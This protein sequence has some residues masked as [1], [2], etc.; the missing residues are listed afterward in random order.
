MSHIHR[1]LLLAIALSL[2][3]SACPSDSATSDTQDT[4][5]APDTADTADTAPVDTDTRDS[6]PAD[7]D[8]DQPPDVDTAPDA[9]P[10]T[11]PDVADT[12]TTDDA[13]LEDT[14]TSDTS[15]GDTAETDTVQGPVAVSRTHWRVTFEDDF[16]GPTGKPSDDYCYGELKPQCHIW[17]GGSFDCDLVGDDR[18]A[19]IEP[20]RDNFIAA[21][22]TL[23][24]DRDYAAMSLGEVKALYGQVIRDR[25]ANLD[26]CNWTL[27][28][29]VNWMATDY[30]G[31]WSARFDATQVE[32][33]TRGKGTL[34]LYAT[35]APMQTN[36]IFGGAGGDPNCQIH[37]FAAGALKVGVN[38]WVDPN[39]GWPGVYY[40]P[41]GGTCPNG[42]TFT[43]VNCLVYAFPPNV[44][45]AR[46][47]SY[48]AD[49]DP[50]WPGV[51]YANRAYACRDNIDYS[52]DL[53]FRNLTC[54]ILNGGVMSFPMTNR[55]WTDPDGVVQPRGVAQRRGRFEAKAK[56]PKGIGAF[57]AT[58][59]MPIEGGWPYKGGEIDVMEARD[60]ADEVYQTYH[61]GKCYDPTTKQRIDAEDSADC[62]R[63]GGA[64]THLSKGFTTR[65]R[66]S[67]EFWKRDHLYAVEWTETP[68]GDRLDYFIN[69]LKIGTI[70]VGTS[71]T[72]T[73]GAPP[74]LAAYERDN[75][76]TSPFYWILNH[77]TWVG[78]NNQASFAQ[79]TFAIDYVRNYV[80]CGTDP[81]EYC[82][83]GG[84]FVE[85]T[86]CIGPNGRVSPSPCQPSARPC[87]NGG[88]LVG[89]RCKVWDFAPGQIAAAP[90]YWVDPDPQWPGVYYAKVNGAC[91]YGGEGTV[92]CQIVG[93]PEGLVET[94]VSYLVDKTT[95]PPGVYYTPDFRD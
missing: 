70:Q 36:C 13:A 87:V 18:R 90:A 9:A 29:M 27:Y 61:N 63:K 67:D 74:Q 1:Q 79:Q 23:L 12:D 80:A 38:Y 85:G 37:A 6:G 73:E 35:R 14:D 83:Q 76:P 17:P 8:E 82:P 30:Q 72:L 86:G 91:P 47:V 4:V 81:R 55:L 59:L 53:A 69:N 71:G 22:K 28:T 24:P 56:I 11:A 39:P 48:W 58:W 62:A 20:V 45:E 2:P 95:S 89:G 46:D 44:L 84:R 77:S 75:F 5:F 10:D 57:P 21:L 43:G 16:R 49:A 15:S 41:T 68:A 32:V 88:E 92:N 50:R 78:A 66:V 19:P 40:A 34:R 42:G 25:L 64:T 60:A 33:D 54:P 52:P 3:L 51:Y 65:Q 7:F 26:K 93:F 94:G 31:H